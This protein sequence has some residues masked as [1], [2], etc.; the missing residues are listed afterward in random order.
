[1]KVTLKQ[2]EEAFHAR[3]L[4]DDTQVLAAGTNE[5]I[6]LGDVRRTLPAPFGNALAEPVSNDTP[7]VTAS[8][9]FQESSPHPE[10]ASRTEPWPATAPTNAHS[11]AGD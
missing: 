1:V 6:S 9:G 2:L 3:L 4:D 10:P 8:S 5:W 7:A 11:S